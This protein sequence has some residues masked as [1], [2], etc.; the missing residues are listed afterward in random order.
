MLVAE[1][2]L[3]SLVKAYGKHV[4]YSLMMVERGI[5]RLVTL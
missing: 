1:A 5:L 4:V 2:F 3:K